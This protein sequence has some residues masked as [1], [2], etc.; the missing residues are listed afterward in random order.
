MRRL[1]DNKF[2]EQKGFTLI[3]LLAVIVILGIIAAI[4]IPSITTIINN[5]KE[6]AIRAD[7]KLILNAA[8]LYY[9]E[10]GMPKDNLGA[11]RAIVESDLEPAYI[12][13]VSSFDDATATDYSITLN[14]TSKE[15]QISGIGKNGSVS[16]EFTNDTI[17]EIE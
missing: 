17:S 2:K 8:K 11:V 16:F 9:T 15:L 12:D 4:A 10:N 7:G 13:N 14:A 3:E 1:L 5:S 6:D